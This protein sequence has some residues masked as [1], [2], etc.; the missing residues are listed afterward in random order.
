MKTARGGNTPLHFAVVYYN[1]RALRILVLN[2]HEGKSMD[3]MNADGKTPKDYVMMY[4]SEEDR[5]RLL[6]I[7]NKEFS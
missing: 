1:L 7:L 4:K 5:N 2:N 6:M 3:I